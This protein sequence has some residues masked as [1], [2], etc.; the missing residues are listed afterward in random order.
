METLNCTRCA[1]YY[2]TW[3]PQHPHGCRAFGFKSMALPARIVEQSSERP[4]QLFQE[5][6]L[7][8]T[9]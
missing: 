1:E 4:C 5:K 8:P 2:V 6:P 9:R 3:E 7:K